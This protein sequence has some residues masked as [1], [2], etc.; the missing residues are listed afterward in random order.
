MRSVYTCRALGSPSNVAMASHPGGMLNDM[1][2]AA[3]R[4]V[5]VRAQFDELSC[6][7][8]PRQGALR[9]DACLLRKGWTPP[10]KRA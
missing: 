2:T 8:L 3:T 5:A 9:Y 7:A 6:N 4:S 10:A 1:S